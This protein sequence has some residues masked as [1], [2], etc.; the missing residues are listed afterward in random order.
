MNAIEAA[1]V[2]AMEGASMKAIEAASMKLLE[3]C[4]EAVSIRAVE[5]D[6]IMNYP[7]FF[8]SYLFTIT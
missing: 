5:V 4:S 6:I 1:S 8:L 7:F 2:K 3:S